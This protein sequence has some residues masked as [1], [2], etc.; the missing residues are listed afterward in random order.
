M[1]TDAR[2]LQACP[3][4]VAVVP[5][6]RRLS[7][8]AWP[9]FNE[10]TQ[11]R[12]QSPAQGHLGGKGQ[13]SDLNPDLGFRSLRLRSPSMTET[14][15]PLRAARAPP[16][17]AHRRHRARPGPRGTIPAHPAPRTPPPSPGPSPGLLGQAL[18]SSSK[19]E[20]QG[21]EAGTANQ[22]QQGGSCVPTTFQPGNQIG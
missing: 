15:L 4:T 7:L 10:E 20:T 19:R 16:R 22:V 9:Q 17:L 5:Q 12:K 6:T 14:R 11:P 13:T 2:R 18:Q 3:P 8:S 21:R 1:I